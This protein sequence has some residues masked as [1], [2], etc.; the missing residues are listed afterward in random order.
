MKKRSIFICQ[1]TTYEQQQIKESIENFLINNGYENRL[2]EITQN[3]MDG[4]LCDLEDDLSIENIIP[5]ILKDIC[6]SW[7]LDFKGDLLENIDD[8]LEQ[9]GT[10]KNYIEYLINECFPVWIEESK[11]ECKENTELYINYQLRLKNIVNE[12]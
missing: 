9:H 10:I 5:S 8:I 3:A 2:E 1:L 12:L 7:E 4:R 6:N 11:T